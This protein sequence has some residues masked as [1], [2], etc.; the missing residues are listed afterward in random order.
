MRGAAGLLGNAELIASIDWAQ[1]PLGD[2]A[3]WSPALRT[4]LQLVLENRFPMVFWWGP[5]LVQLYNDRYTPILGEK[6][7]QSM[8]QSGQAC[9]EEIWDVIGPQITSVYAGGP[10]TWNEDLLLDIN[11]HGFVE[12]TYFTF[13]YSALPDPSAPGGIGGVLGTVQETTEKV[14]GER[15]MRLLRDLA[16]RSTEART[17]ED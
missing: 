7:P 8:G 12:E 2:A 5:Q 16:A 14:I 3:N 9:W 10:S 6:H 15:R 13:S 11:R 4:V 17:V 1:T